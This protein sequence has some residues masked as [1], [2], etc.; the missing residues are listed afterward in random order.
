[1]GRRARP[2]HRTGPGARSGPGGQGPAV[3]ACGL[4]QRRQ[5]TARYNCDGQ[6][7]WVDSVEGAVPQVDE[8]GART[9]RWAAY[10]SVAQRLAQHSG[11][12][13]RY[14]QGDELLE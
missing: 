7:A 4:G 11:L 8:T 12:A 14:L 2:L 3:R 9:E 6:T 10:Q 1:M 13:A 5:T